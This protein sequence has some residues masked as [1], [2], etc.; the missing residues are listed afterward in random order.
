MYIR[1]YCIHTYY[2][3]T[4]PPIPSCRC[5]DLVGLRPA[6]NLL[7]ERGHII[8]YVLVAV[9]AVCFYV[10]FKFR[11]VSEGTQGGTLV[12]PSFPCLLKI[13]DANTSVKKFK[14]MS[15][16]G[17]KWLKDK[18]IIHYIDTYVCIIHTYT[19]IRIRITSLLNHPFRPH[20]VKTW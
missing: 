13:Y 2:V 18:P 17:L 19:Y 10:L 9:F 1:M 3:L 20:A 12:N 15:L 14:K 5:K 11:F 4:K 6:G 7:H 8:Y 16:N